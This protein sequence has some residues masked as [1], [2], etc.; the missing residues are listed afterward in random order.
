MLS[1]LVLAVAAGND[2]SGGDMVLPKKTGYTLLVGGIPK[3]GVMDGDGVIDPATM[4]AAFVVMGGVPAV[5]AVETAV[6]E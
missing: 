6:Q 3:G 5:V 1:A 4:L 2:M